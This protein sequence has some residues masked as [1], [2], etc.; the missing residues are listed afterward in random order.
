MSQLYPDLPVNFPDRLDSFPT[1]FNIVASDGPLIAQYQEAMS[2]GDID[3]ANQILA[4]IPNGTQKIIKAV[5][6]NQLSSAILAVERFYKENI[7]SYV[8]NKQ[9]EWLNVINQFSYKGVWSIG[10]SYQVNNFVTYATS[11]FTMLYI[12]TA[13]PPVGNAPTDIN[14]WRLLTIQ[15]QQGV[16]GEGLAYR[17]KWEPTKQYGT[18]DVVTYDG[19]LWMTLQPSQGITP[20]EDSISS[21][22]WK[23][24]LSL[25]AT[26][27]PI[28]DTPPAN[29][30]AGE[31]WFNTSN[32][33]TK[34]YYLKDLD[35]PAN[36]ESVLEG[37]QAYDANGNL[38]V[39]TYKFFDSVLN[40]NSWEKISQASA[41]GK[42]SS[43]W[44]V[45]DAK[46]I[47]LNGTIASL[48]LSNYK[49]WVYI[50][51][52]NHNAEKEGNNLIH[53]G[54]FRSERDYSDINS[55]ALVDSQYGLGTSDNYFTMITSNTNSSGWIHSHMRNTVI[56][57]AST[58]A[59][60]A[61]NGTFLAALPNDLKAV[62][63][64]C[65]KYTCNR[66]SG[67]S[68][69]ERYITPTQ[70]LAFLLSEF[71]VQ[72]VRSY[73][74]VY[75]QN[76][77][78]QYEYYRLGNSKIKYGYGH[79]NSVCVWWCRSLQVAY[80]AGFCLVGTNGL[81]DRSGVSN[82]SRGFAPAF[83]V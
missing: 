25:E 63:K 74:S 82:S 79:T 32:N 4:E 81:A 21:Q 8:D 60:A 62:L 19:A 7:E 41:S 40:N 33:Q 68:D 27:Y 70:D 67:T 9:Q 52:F 15:G 71:E 12:A 56:S 47:T 35:N 11:G 28:Q 3:R 73:A 22:Y 49:T 10:E 37:F 5:D 14:Y 72:G 6:L 46:E 54:C 77:Q 75:E 1:W 34:Y 42:A 69:E 64:K 53:F 48:T 43:L 55:I 78:K 44:S 17:Q 13:T 80:D 29:Q 66:L 26:A 24:V 36:A 51:G 30:K 65:T 16:S 18:N 2:E 39:G 31:L 59:M 23:K 50:L 38:I 58:S 45:G 20:S 76:Y 83:C 61:I 57:A